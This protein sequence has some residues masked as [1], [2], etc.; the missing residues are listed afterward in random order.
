MKTAITE[1]TGH[2]ETRIFIYCWWEYDCA[3]PMANSIVAPVAI[4]FNHSIPRPYAKELKTET[5]MLTQFRIALFITTKRQ[6][7][8][9]DERQTKQPTDVQWNITQYNRISSTGNKPSEGDK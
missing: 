8:P 4:G 5:Q 6:K 1:K 3:A 2:A 9:S 7:E